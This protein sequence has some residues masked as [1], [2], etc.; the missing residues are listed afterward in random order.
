MALEL[1][2][3]DV[4]QAFEREELR[5]K[6][7]VSHENFQK[8]CPFKL[9]ETVIDH[10]LKSA[11]EPHGVTCVVIGLPLKRASSAMGE[12]RVEGAKFYFWVK[13]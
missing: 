8:G 5:R 9:G 7:M 1:L 11:E 13:T 4:L 3:A 10:T 6:L 12:S 2:A